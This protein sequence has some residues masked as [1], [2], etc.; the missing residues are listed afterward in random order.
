MKFLARAMASR[1]GGIRISKSCRRQAQSALLARLR[2]VGLRQRKL[3][4]LRA[5]SP[6][7]G[8][9][10]RPFGPA[11]GSDFLGLIY[12]TILAIF[13][14]ESEIQFEII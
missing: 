11:F 13:L 2:R 12:L 4:T 7:V 8:P 10:F 9:R 6:Q 1:R 5:D 3:S 14:S